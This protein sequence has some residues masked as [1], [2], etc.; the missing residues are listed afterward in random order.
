MT[1]VHYPSGGR[2]SGCRAGSAKA[3]IDVTLLAVL[4]VAA[5]PVAVLAGW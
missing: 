4:L 1:G 2:R 5:V 3:V